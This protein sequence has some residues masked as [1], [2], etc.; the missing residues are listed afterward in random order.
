MSVNVNIGQSF[1][2]ITADRG[3]LQKIGYGAV[4]MLI[5]FVGAA[6]QVIETARN[7]AQG[8]PDPLPTWKMDETLGP[9]LMRGVYACLIS[10]IYAIPM[11]V[12]QMVFNILMAMTKSGVA[13]MIGCLAAPVNLVVFIATVLVVLPALVRYVQTDN[14]RAALDFQKVIGMLQESPQLWLILLLVDILASVITL[15]GLVAFIIGVFV[16]MAIGCA[17]FGHALGQVASQMESASQ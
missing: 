16:T 11:I 9:R 13:T 6:T 7:V 5:P 10:L 1:S 4:A 17:V 8:K 2:F 3:W 15:L 12:I 14:W